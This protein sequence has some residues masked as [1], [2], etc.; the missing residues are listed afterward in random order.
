MKGEF[1]NSSGDYDDDLPFKEREAPY[2]FSKWLGYEQGQKLF[3]SNQCL[4]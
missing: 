2:K 1:H 4:V 3:E